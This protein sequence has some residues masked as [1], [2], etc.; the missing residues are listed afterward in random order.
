[1]RVRHPDRAGIRPGAY[2][3]TGRSGRRLACRP[4]RDAH[5]RRCP[6]GRDLSCPRHHH[7]DDPRL[8][9]PMCPD[10]YDYTGHV[11]FNALAPSCGA[12]LPS[13]CR[14]SSP[15]SPESPGASCAAKSGSGSSRSPNTS[16]AASSTT[17]P[18]SGLTLRVTATS[19][20]ATG[21]L[22]SCSTKPSV[23]PWP[24]SVTT[25]PPS[26]VTTHRCGVS[27]GWHP[28]RHPGR[29]ADEQLARHRKGPVH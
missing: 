25:P 28:G 5:H 21:T 26:P 10:C 17:T 1:M 8:G 3:P 14:A 11:L 20:R 15:A 23:P 4:R 9:T 24:R 2:H 27:R 29:P 6:H 12:G 7:Q 22:P 18:S 16:T 19:R 13:T